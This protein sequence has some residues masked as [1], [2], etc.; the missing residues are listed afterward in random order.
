M[1]TNA[2][3][4]ELQKFSDLAH[5]WWDPTSEFKPL[6]EINPLRLR[7]IDESGRVVPTAEEVARAEARLRAEEARLRVEAERRLAEALAEIERLK[8]SRTSD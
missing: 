5:R 4:A 3:P 8:G 1:N 2:D 7:W 6:H